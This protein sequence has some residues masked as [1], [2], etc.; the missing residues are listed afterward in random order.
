[1]DRRQ[2]DDVKAHLLDV[3]Q[4]LRGRLEG[5]VLT[6]TGCSRTREHLIPGAE[7]GLLAVHPDALTD[8][9]DRL[10]V[11]RSMLEHQF[12]QRRLEG[13]VGAHASGPLLFEGIRALE[14]AVGVRLRSAHGRFADDGGALQKLHRDVLTTLIPLLEVAPPRAELVDPG[15]DL[16]D[17][18]LHLGDGEL[19]S[20]AVVAQEAHRHLLPG[21]LGFEAIEEMTGELVMAVGEGIRL[22]HDGVA[23]GAFDGEPAAIHLR[24]HVLDSDAATIG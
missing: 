1:M 23:D 5:A 8:V 22:D 6:G 11:A 14:E 13:D 18:G 15:F 4:A 2:V 9:V 24:L 3:R 17:V 19:A 12:L 16:V 21:A 20:P 7:A 10:R